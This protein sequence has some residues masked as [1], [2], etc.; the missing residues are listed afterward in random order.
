MLPAKIAKEQVE[1]EIPCRS[2]GSVHPS[3][4]KVLEYGSINQSLWAENAETLILSSI[5]KLVLFVPLAR[6]FL[7][8]SLEI[9]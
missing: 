9:P 5:D 8:A 1:L 3:L 2:T 4:S 6:Q 7:S